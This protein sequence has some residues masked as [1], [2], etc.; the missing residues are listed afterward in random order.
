MSDNPE[1]ITGSQ[2]ITVSSIKE[3]AAE[4]VMDA[5]QTC[6]VFHRFTRMAV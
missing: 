3:A 2:I 6:N 1:M 4:S 5:S